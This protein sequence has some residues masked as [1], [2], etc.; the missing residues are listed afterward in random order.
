[1][2]F[3]EFRKLARKYS[4]SVELVPIEEHDD[5]FSAED[6]EIWKIT[7]IGKERKRDIEPQRLTVLSWGNVGV[8]SCEIDRIPVPI[9]QNLSGSIGC[10]LWPSSVVL[11]R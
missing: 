3:K 11:S 5:Y 1:L 10:T 6:I 8:V 2:Y 9:K 7:K 4:L